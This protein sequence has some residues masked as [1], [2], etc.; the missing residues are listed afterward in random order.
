MK[1]YPIL[2]RPFLW[3]LIIL[4]VGLLAS[5]AS[6][7]QDEETSAGLSADTNAIIE[8]RG[9]TPE[10][11]AAA[12]KTYTPSGTHD[13]YIMFSSGG[14]SGQV[15]VIGMPSMRILKKIAVFTPEPWQGYGYGA[16][17][18]MEV[19]QGGN[20]NGREVL[21]GDTHHPA[22]SETGGDY[23]GQFLFINDKANARIAL[24]DLKDFETKQI[25]KN[26]IAVNDHGGTF[27]T[28]NTDWV[29]EGG[30]YAAPLGGAYSSLDNYAEDYRGMVTIWKFDRAAGRIVP[31]QS[32]ALELPPYWQDL[33]DAGKLVSDGWIFCNSFN[34]EMAT[35]G[36]EDGNAPFESGASQR[37]MDY[38][39][40][41]NLNKAAEI[42]AAGK[43]TEINGFP[44]IM[45]DTA[46]AEGLLYFAPEPKSPH[47][48]DVAPGGEYFVISGKLDP[49]VTVY[50]WSKIQD[51]IANEK[52]TS[53]DYGV[54]VLDFDA[55]VEA[56]VE[57]GLGPLHTQFGPDGYAY[58]SLFLDTAVARWTLGGDYDKLNDDPPWSLVQKTPV[59][60]N[61][62]HIAAAEGDTVSPDGQY[63]VS[64]NKWAVDRFANVGPLLPQNFQLID[65]SQPGTTMPVLYD[66][67]IPDGEPHYAQIIKADKL[68]PWEVYPEIGWNPH[69][70]AVDPNAVQLG[71]ERIERNG[72]EVEIWMTAVR[73]HFTPEH[74]EI[75]QGDHVIWHITNVERAYDATHGFSIPAY[76]IN[77][78]IEPGEAVTF[79]FDA[80]DDG[81]FSYYC[82]EFC[83]ALH[84]EMV[85]YLLIE[86]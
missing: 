34:T 86:P 28:P 10:D 37:D 18:T 82:T 75:K 54:P 85:G 68:Q 70:G 22:L 39:H 50:S 27:V 43:T 60:Y 56:Q 66:M 15:Y 6:C 71:E 49:H 83:S 57:L 24:I 8:A 2:R 64:L 5:V 76:N 16:S 74:V 42:A 44:V 72:N 13:E 63:L 30:Q 59:Q 73:S 40:I 79:E 62:G 51:A 84:L 80:T 53:D 25:I 35:G 81:V 47:G 55:V 78:S 33:C 67:P 48:V 36:V 65:I 20:V 61:V 45:L 77:L 69:T 19:L 29:I 9:L 58:T 21:W 1:P 23:D 38:L 11:V 32:F 46:I 3:L 52:W 31:G 41:I 7:R 17:G 26:P 4:T 14:H 12:L